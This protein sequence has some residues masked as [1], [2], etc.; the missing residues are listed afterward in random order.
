MSRNVLQ[1]VGSFH[2]GGSE[3][4][5]VQLARLL[6]ESGRFQVRLA[7]LDGSGALRE[8][9]ER[10]GFG[11]IPEYKLNNFYDRRMFAQLRRFARYLREERI[12]V[13]HAH[14]FYTNVFGMLG[15]AL[16]RVPARVASRR[17]TLGV[18][19]PAQKW[20][21]RR[22]YRL[23]HAVVANAGAVREQLAREGVDERKVAVVYNGLDTERLRPA[24]NLSRGERLAL[25]GLPPGLAARPLVTIVANMRLNVKDQPTFLRA[26]RRVREQVP[27]AAFV[28]AGEGEL[29]EPLRALAAE[30]GLREHAF[31]AGRCARV[32]ELLEASSVCV[33][34]SRAEGFSN[35][36]LEYMAAARAVVATDVGGAREAVAEGETGYLVPAGDDESLA[37]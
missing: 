26:A 7:C 21:E 27:Q 11:E 20:V 25:V 36:I 6:S 12:A 33:L 24:E 8:E 10:L 28:L 4:Q 23:A 1:L 15:A 13:V 16:A 37:A 17:E 2:Q 22:A 9:A 32:A 14:D 30:L 31:F 34:S 35:A 19:S 3:R 18:R 29:A 5:A